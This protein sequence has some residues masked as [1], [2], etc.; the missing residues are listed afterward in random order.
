MWV[1]VEMEWNYLDNNLDY[2]CVYGPYYSEDKA[3][4]VYDKFMKNKKSHLYYEIK[5]LMK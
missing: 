5:K 2:L 1:I 3:K 4:K